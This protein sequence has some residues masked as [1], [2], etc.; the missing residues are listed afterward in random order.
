MTGK[1]K[2]ARRASSVNPVTSYAKAVT[3]GKIIAGP[4]VR[5]AC[6]RHLDDLKNGEKRGLTFD[7]KLAER[8]ISFY[9][10]VLRLNG[11]EYEGR[12]Y[13]LLDWQC[14]IVGSIFGWVGPDGFRRFRSVYVETAKGSGKSPLAAGV[15]LYGMMA[16]GEPGAEIYAAAT[17]K[18]QAMILF[19]DAVAMVDHSPDLSSRI[20]KSG[21]GLNVWNLA[22]TAR[23]SFFR[24]ISADNG[25]SGPRP[26]VSLLDEVHEHK[27]AYVIEML[28]AGQKS[29]RQPLL[30]AIT[31]SG[32][33]KRTV[34]WD[35]HDYGAKVCAGQIEDD[36]FFAYICAMDETD[37]PFKDEDCW[38][39]ANPSLRFELP[40]WRYLR[41]QVAQAR[42]MPSKESIVRRLN[43]CQWVEAESPWISGEVWFGCED[44]EFD[45]SLLIGRRCYGGLDLSSTQDLTALVLMFEPTED[46]PHWRQ[47]EWFWLP[48]DGLH[49]KA[50]QDRAPYVMWRDKEYLIALPGRA[51]NKLAVAKQA[52]EISA[53]YDLQCLAYDRWRIEDLKMILDQ[54]GISLPLASF[55]QGFK[56]M[57][58]A[59]D[60]YERRLLNGVIRHAGNPVMTWCAANAVTMSDPAG[61][62][63]IAK[64]KATGRVDGIVAAIMATGMTITDQ[65]TAP[66]IGPDYELVVC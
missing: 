51:V 7:A 10:E 66:V 21:T 32:T 22:W 3:S 14:F 27:D 55:G 53:M 46:D 24:P 2:T 5:D 45:D 49:D 6:R 11:G 50:D 37:D 1:Q 26:H 19:R 13:E 35:Y 9:R 63:K 36:T 20:T 38:H 4:H 42:G 31:N 65:E 23:R 30:F 39:K 41:E 59:V 29:R 34:C 64:E 17:K 28:K 52:A 61:N 8:G 15:G 54:E 58:P 16:D 62:K 25:Q 40:G 44:K 60:E 12:P 56:D 33:D 43:F 18:D 47:K 48:G 57:A